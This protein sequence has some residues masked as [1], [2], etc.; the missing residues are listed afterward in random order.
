MK[1]PPP[2]PPAMPSGGHQLDKVFGDPQMLSTHPMYGKFPLTLLFFEF[3]NLHWL[4]WDF[5]LLKLLDLFL[6]FVVFYFIIGFSWIFILR[7]RRAIRL[8]SIYSYIAHSFVLWQQ[9]FEVCSGSCRQMHLYRNKL[10]LDWIKWCED[11]HC[12]RNVFPRYP[13]LAIQKAKRLQSQPR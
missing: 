7:R 4:M 8:L 11:I 2:P 9:N 10:Q 3:S 6:I 12:R 1:T 13:Q 5:E